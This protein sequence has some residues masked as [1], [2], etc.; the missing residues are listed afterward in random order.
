MADVIS[1]NIVIAK[2]PMRKIQSDIEVVA[3]TITITGLTSEMAHNFLGVQF[4]ADS[5]GAAPATPGA[6]TIAVSVETE[7]TTPV[8]EDPPDPAIDATAPDTLTWSGN[9]K[10]VKL[11]PTGITTATHWRALWTGNRS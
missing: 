4:F 1:R 2:G 10:S 9:T 8:F 6:G 7:N 5:A 3:D 11:I